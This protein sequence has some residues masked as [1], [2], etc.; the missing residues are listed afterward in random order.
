[1]RILKRF[2]ILTFVMLAIALSDAKAANITANA[3]STIYRKVA[4]EIRM[5]PYYGV[6]DII[7]YEVDGRTVAPSGRGCNAMNR[8]SAERRIEDIDG[9]ETVVN[10]I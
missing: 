10:N 7:S 4:K 5:S 6:F 1:M 2:P 9:A 3:D 8:N